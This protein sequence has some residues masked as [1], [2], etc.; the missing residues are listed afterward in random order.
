MAW[1][2]KSKA[3]WLKA[4]DNNTK[5]FHKMASQRRCINRIL[6]MQI[7]GNLHEGQEVIKRGLV[8]HFKR[9]FRKR[10][11]WKPAWADNT[12][13]RLSADFVELL[14]APIGEARSM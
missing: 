2:E 5:F 1:R 10:R 3:L 4:G 11:G 7:D 13:P 9:N 14:E 8:D 6:A 12:L